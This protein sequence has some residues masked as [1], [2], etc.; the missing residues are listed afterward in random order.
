MV[1]RVSENISCLVS[2]CREKWCNK[3][4]KTMADYAHLIP[5]STGSCKLQFSR[6]LA[7]RH[8]QHCT[9]GYSAK[10][11]NSFWLYLR[12][13]AVEMLRRTF[14]NYSSWRI[15][16]AIFRMNSAFDSMEES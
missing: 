11:Y 5:T 13:L 12:K 8:F 3:K 2:I 14:V 10:A 1:C 6:F 4:R 7:A 15:L 9:A 16:V